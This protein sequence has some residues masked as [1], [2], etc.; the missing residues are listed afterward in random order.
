MERIP[1]SRYS[2]LIEDAYSCIPPNIAKLISHVHFFCGT[3]PVYAGL[4][5]EK[6][7]IFPGT[8]GVFSTR[9][10]IYY[11]N[12]NCTDWVINKSLRSPTIF[13]PNFNSIPKGFALTTHDVLHELGHVLDFVLP[14]EILDITPVT[15]YAESSNLE[16]FAES[17]VSWL[18]YGYG[19]E[20]SKEIVDLFERLKEK[21]C[22]WY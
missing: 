13:L 20:P 12:Y 11:M 10:W 8:E 16:A 4:V 19:D 3:D 1:D 18:L 9:N 5:K 15:E 21:E 14:F 6:T 22:G 7:L 17:F 2:E